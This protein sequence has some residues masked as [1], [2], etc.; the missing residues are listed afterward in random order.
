MCNS[1]KE[2]SKKP[3]CMACGKSTEGDEINPSF[4][5]NKFNELQSKYL[6]GGGDE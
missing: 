1:C 5:E 6:N 4:D 2:E 3:K